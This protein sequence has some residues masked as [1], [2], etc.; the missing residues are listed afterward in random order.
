M[1]KSLL[2]SAAGLAALTFATA[3]LA[4]DGVETV[5]V[6]ATRLPTPHKTN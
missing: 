2:L 1:R 3:A 5:V 6:T 4:D